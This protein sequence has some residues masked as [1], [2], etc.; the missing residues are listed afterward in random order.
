[1]GQLTGAADEQRQPP[2]TYAAPQGAAP[3]LPPGQEATG[4]GLP[5]TR[6]SH[7]GEKRTG[8][9]TT[10][11]APG[12]AGTAGAAPGLRPGQGATGEGLPRTRGGHRGR[13]S[14]PR[15]WGGHRGVIPR[16]K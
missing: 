11:T 9:G 4:E 8:A 14:L 13:H 7:H 10:Q 5:R 1:M 12:T 15:N 6:D 3:G 16:G 2:E